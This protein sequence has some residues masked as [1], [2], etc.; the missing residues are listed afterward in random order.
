MTLNEINDMFGIMP[1]AGGDRRL[2]SLNY[3]SLDHVD[4]YQKG[5]AGVAGAKKKEEAEPNEEESE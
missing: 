1:F 3:V 2:Q 4:G 5:R